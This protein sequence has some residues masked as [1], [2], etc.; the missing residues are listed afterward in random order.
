MSCLSVSCVIA[1][2]TPVVAHR[3][4]IG[5]DSEFP[6]TVLQELAFSATELAFSRNSQK[7]AEILN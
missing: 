4:E 3:Y 2:N 7:I 6:V 1:C 5:T